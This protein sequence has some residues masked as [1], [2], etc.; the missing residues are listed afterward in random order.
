MESDENDNMINGDGNY[1]M[2]S[3][4]MENDNMSNEEYNN[5]DYGNED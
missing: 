4:E 2:N 5:E 1:D 3:D